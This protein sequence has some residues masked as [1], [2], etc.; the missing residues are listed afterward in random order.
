[1][2][3]LFFFF[4]YSL[5]CFMFVFIFL[6]SDFSQVLISIVKTNIYA[7]SKNCYL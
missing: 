1:M 2:K 7:K 5:I 4:D 6:S 3:F